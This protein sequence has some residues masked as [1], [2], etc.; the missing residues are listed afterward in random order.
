MAV[1]GRV[2]DSVNHGRMGPRGPYGSTPWTPSADRLTR[3]VIRR[4]G[5]LGET[6]RATAMGQGRCQLA[7]P[8]TS[9]TT[10]TRELFVNDWGCRVCGLDPSDIRK[11]AR[12]FGRSEYVL[13]TVSTRGPWVI[14]SLGFK[15]RAIGRAGME[16][17]E[18]GD[19]LHV[20][21]QALATKAFVVYVDFIPAPRRL[22]VQN[23][24]TCAWRSVGFEV[25]IH[26]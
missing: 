18:A 1:R 8:C 25:Q 9:C 3:P 22:Q 20:N 26:P 24:I 6:D 10:P 14:S 15:V 4:D 12:P 5:E 11:A 23:N 16:Y 7:P 13:S 2:G 21:S 19:S 17:V